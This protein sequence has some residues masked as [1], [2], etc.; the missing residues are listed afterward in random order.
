MPSR[1]CL[2]NCPGFVSKELKV[3]VLLMEHHIL[4]SEMYFDDY[5]FLTV[6]QTACKKFQTP[7]PANAYCNDP[8]DYLYC[9]CK[10]GFSGDG[11]KCYGNFITKLLSS[12]K[13]LPCF[14]YYLPSSVVHGCLVLNLIR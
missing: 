13:F 5:I 7:C 6:G 3:I 2:L 11:S 14:L 10:P 9:R 8:K 4:L 1:T 12:A